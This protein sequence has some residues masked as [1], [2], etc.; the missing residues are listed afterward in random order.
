MPLPKRRPVFVGRLHTLLCNKCRKLAAGRA[1]DRWWFCLHAGHHHQTLLTTKKYF[2]T[3][4]TTTNGCVLTAMI[5][6]A[7]AP[8]A[9]LL[10]VASA[11]GAGN[12]D[13]RWHER[14]RSPSASGAA[15]RAA[16]IEPPWCCTTRPVL[17]ITESRSWANRRSSSP[18]T[19]S[20]WFGVTST[21]CVCPSGST[22]T[23]GVILETAK[24]IVTFSGCSTAGN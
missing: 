15:S 14:A 3:Q 19:S 13:A 10:L 21:R 9:A 11:G 16:L 1:V 2:S 23:G 17:T 5:F 4:E 20:F 18:T 22:G 6:A 12:F 8:S 24:R 7:Q